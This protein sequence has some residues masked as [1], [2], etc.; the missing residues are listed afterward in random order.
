MDVLD[1]IKQRRS[2][3]EFTDDEVSDEQINKILESAR[4]APSG[5]NNQPW[6]FVVIKNKKIKNELSKFTKYGWIIKNASIA[7]ATFIDNSVCYD[8]TKDVQSIGACIQN[9]LIAIQ[10]LGLGGCWIGEILNKRNE[11]ENFLGVPKNYEL[12]AVI[13]IGYPRQKQ[14]KSQRESLKDL[15][16]KV[17][18]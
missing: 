18:D 3:R 5:M 1:I 6:R 17:I 14:R 4:W 7:I 12:M 16:Y 9:M 13:T 11:V 2:V 15:I 10:S 8:R